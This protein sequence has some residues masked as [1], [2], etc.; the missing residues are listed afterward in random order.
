MKPFPS[1]TILL[2][3]IGIAPVACTPS[4][5]DQWLRGHLETET[6]LVQGSGGVSMNQRE[7]FAPVSGGRYA[8]TRGDSIVLEGRKIG[9]LESYMVDRIPAE[10]QGEIT[11]SNLLVT[12]IR[13]LDEQPDSTTHRIT[14]TGQTYIG[15]VYGLVGSRRRG[16]AQQALLLWDGQENYELEILPG[17]TLAGPDGTRAIVFDGMGHFVYEARAAL[18]D[19]PAGPLLRVAGLRHVRNATPADET[20][21]PGVSGKYS[22]DPRK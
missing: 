1:C 15:V 7:F 9:S 5:E 18:H 21:S 19:L 14:E 4:F 11:A 6:A 3:G 17:A 10:V 16:G 20:G 2:V 13:Y 12:H 8:V 22:T